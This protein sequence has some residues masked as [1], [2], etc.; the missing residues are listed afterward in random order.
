MRAL[1]GGK[2]VTSVDVA[3]LAEVSQATVSRVFSASKNLSQKTRRKVL[4]AARELGYQPNA[5][6]RS[7]VSSRSNLIGI[8]K[9]YTQNPLFSLI[10]TEFTH[11]IQDMGKQVLYFEAKRR[12]D[13]DDVMWNVL[14]YQV[15][16]IIL[17]YTALSS[18]LTASCRQRDIPVL[19][20]LRYSPGSN[21][22]IFVSDNHRAAGEA[23]SHLA[24]RGFRKFVYIAGETNSSTNMERYAGMVCRLKEMGYSAPLVAEGDFTYDSGRKAMRKIAGKAKAPLGVFCAT[25][26]LALGVIDTARHDLKWRIPEDVGVVGFDDIYLANWPEYSLTTMRQ[27]VAEM[28]RDGLKT[29]C[30]N[31][32]DKSRRPVIRKYPCVLIKRGST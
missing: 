30:L 23:V 14:K 20:M 21:A 11:R 4:A 31:I 6:A 27:P 10:L 13:I 18:A 7:L 26:M 9:G 32:E 5:I 8:V 28:V 19:Q 12:Q 22:N 29:L 2:H 17:L 25:D 24:E 1:K 16:G 15:E 3:K